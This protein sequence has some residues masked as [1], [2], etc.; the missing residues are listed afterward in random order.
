MWTTIL[1]V[2]LGVWKGAMAYNSAE[3]EA[4]RNNAVIEARKASLSEQR[5]YEK[6]LFEIRT[7]SAYWAAESAGTVRMARQMAL[8]ARGGTQGLR[9]ADMFRVDRDRWLGQKEQRFKDDQMR[10]HFREL[11]MGKK[12]PGD[13]AWYAGLGA[14]LDTIVP[15]IAYTEKNP[16]KG[17]TTDTT[18]TGTT[19]K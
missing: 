19:A 3:E 16:P 5:R 17:A 15:F 1:S 11:D 18:T 9:Q 2:G 14:A 10:R 8:G 6:E 13:E 4:E 12:D 7:F